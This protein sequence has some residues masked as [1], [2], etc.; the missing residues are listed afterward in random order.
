MLK[1]TRSELRYL[2]VNGTTITPRFSSA[3]HPRLIDQRNRFLSVAAAL[4][5]TLR[6]F[7]LVSARMPAPQS[8]VIGP[9]LTSGRGLTDRAARINPELHD[10]EVP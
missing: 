1:G 4:V 8:R 3:K 10:R 9:G 5:R 6:P 7:V 2:G